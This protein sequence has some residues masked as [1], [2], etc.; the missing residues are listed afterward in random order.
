MPRPAPV[1]KGSANQRAQRTVR[2][3]R[4]R[5][6]RIPLSLQGATPVFLVGE[7]FRVRGL[8]R[9]I[10]EGGVLVEVVQPPPIGTRVEVTFEAIEGSRQA[11]EALALLGEVRHQV[12]WSFMQRGDTRRLRGVGIRFL[13]PRASREA[14]SSWIFR[15]G[16]SVH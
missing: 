13:E 4:R 10:S 11:S 14:A 9:N 1:P 8:A 2:S 6:Q 12:A 7:G 5:G 15:T 3:D 16:H